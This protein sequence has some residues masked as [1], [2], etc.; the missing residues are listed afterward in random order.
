MK[1]NILP[2]VLFAMI[3]SSCGTSK[4]LE[5]ANAQIEILNNRVSY[6]T[7]QNF[8]LNSSL[9]E[10]AKLSEQLKEENIKQSKQAED[11]RK[12]SESVAQ[13]LD[14]LNRTLEEQGNTLEEIK[15]KAIHGLSSY[16]DAGITVKY[17]NG[18]VYISMQDQF[19]FPSGS[20]KINDGGIQALSVV[21]GIL[22]EYKHVS[23]IIVGNTDTLKVNKGYKDNWSLSTERANAIV[24]LLRDTYSADPTRLTAAG[25]SKY[26]PVASNESPEGRA[27]NRRTDIIINP[28]LSRLWQLSQKHP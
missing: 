13:R 21:A 16:Q 12:T 5:A 18:M 20:T 1:G 15:R 22:A 25:K 10:S 19:M 24:R 11:C 17:R 28:D 6:L 3:F 9:S 23:A 26:N 8:R 2:F 4:K 7:D 27:K 14:E